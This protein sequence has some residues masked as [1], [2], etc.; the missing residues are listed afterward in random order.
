M[1][2]TTIARRQITRKKIVLFTLLSWLRR[3]SKLALLVI[4][5]L[6]GARKLKQG[7]LY[8][9]V[10]N[11]V[12]AQVKA[13]GSYDLV[14]PNG[15]TKVTFSDDV[16]VVMDN[17]N[18]DGEVGSFKSTSINTENNHGAAGVIGEDCTLANV[19]IPQEEVD[20][21]SARFENSL[22]GY[23]VGR[24][25]AFPVVQNYA[26]N[27]WGKYGFKN[28]MVH[29]GFFM[30]QFSTKESMEN[31]LDQGP[32]RIR[33]VPLILNVWNPISELKREDIKKVPVWVKLFNVPVVAYSKVGLNLIT[34]KLGRLI[35]FDA[36]TSNM[37]LNSW[38]MNSYARV[39]VEISAEK[40]LVQSLVVVVPIDK[41]KGHRLVSI[42][43][44]FEYRP[45]RCSVCKVFDHIDKECHK[46]EKEEIQ[47]TNKE[48]GLGY[49]KRKSKGINQA[50]KANKTSRFRFSN[51]KPKLIYRPVVKPTNTMLS[52]SKLKDSSS[53]YSKED[54][55][56]ACDKP[57]E[58]SN[59]TTNDSSRPTN[60]NAKSK[61]IQDDIDLGQL[62]SYIDKHMKE[63]KT[64]EASK[65]KHHSLSDSEESKV[66]EV[67]MPD[68]ISGG[69]SL[70]RLEDDLDGYDGYEAQFC[71]LNEQGQ[72]FC[73]QYDIRKMTRK[74][75]LHRTERATN[76]LGLIHTN[77]CGP[78]R[79][80][81]RQGAGYF[82][83]FMDDYSLLETF[84]VFNNEVENQL[85]KTIKALRSDREGEYISQEFKDYLKAY[86]IVQQLTPP[87]TP[88]YNRVSKRR[89]HTLLD[90]VRSMMNLI[91]P[92][93]SF[94][95][96]AIESA[97]RILNIVPTKKVD[98]TPY[99]LWYGKVPNVSYLKV[100]GCEALVKRDT[101]DK[102]QQRS[103]KC[104]FIG[105][106]KETMG[107]Y[108][109]FPPENKIV[110]ARYAEFLEKN[111]ISQEVSGR[112]VELE[113]I[114]D[115]DTSPSESTSKIPIEVEGFK[116]PQEEVVPVRRSARIHRAPNR[117]CLNVEVEEH[118]LRDLNEPTNYKAALLDPE[119]DKWLDAM[120][121]KIQS[122]KDNQ[123]W[124][125]VDLSP[126]GKTVGSKWLFKKK[127]DIDGIVHTYKACLVSK[128]FTQTYG[129]DYEETISPIA[130]IR[131]IRILVAIAAFYD[132]EICK[133]DVKTAFLNGY[134]DEDIYMVQPEGFVDP[135]HPRK[136]CKLQ[137]SIYGLKQASRSWNKRFDEEIKRFGFAQNLDEPCVYQKASGSNVTFLILYVD[138]III[139]GNHIPS[140]QSVKS[141]LGKCF[142]M[143]DLGEAAFILGIKIYR[144]R[145]NRLIGLSQS[146]YMDKILKRFKMK[147][148]KHGNIPM[149]ERFDLNKTQGASTP[150]EVKRMKNVPYASTLDLI[151]TKDM[152][153][154]Y[155][156]N[157]EAELRV[158]CYCDA[159]FETDR[160]DIKSQTGYVF[161]LNKGA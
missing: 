133:M 87:Y 121:A 23:F 154:V 65:N 150:G 152:F 83:T 84:K 98:K 156:G 157:H 5:G 28:V 41:N 60:E 94:W 91:T 85:G 8:L 105:Y 128:G 104:I 17:K 53:H 127:A 115:E 40:E 119:S 11:G 4:Q 129:V 52:P 26:R 31:V 118:S 15:L 140:L 117:L 45:P 6:R 134:L 35:K 37:C 107:Y 24:R 161:V 10:G 112:A 50:S 42:E 13:I 124:C 110:V 142:T 2:P 108:F 54:V 106:P 19:I 116:P 7:A 66:E 149:Q 71:D 73:D 90:M 14:L 125:L 72:A 145:S 93:L 114:Q 12:R 130:D 138:D 88:Q 43:I 58:P 103:V 21:L 101:P 141:Y 67:C 95:D 22:Y 18:D 159:G 70:D 51:G 76:L 122:M 79:H 137:R 147:N 44:E 139:M 27:A 47:N 102:L 89:N 46:K 34:A 126:N 131:A 75:F 56:V 82:I 120:N 160:D 109:Y 77:V 25:L 55:N 111:L 20:T 29:Q 80:V 136:V 97:A 33:S 96:Y 144:H 113:E 123:V 1:T 158:D 132:Y 64:R 9:Y 143:K 68:H 148:S 3:G 135:K 30:F 49:D 63:D 69:G 86:G 32:W 61:F 36:H 74:P 57:T 146:D 92:P 153:L 48:D 81:S 78:L 39:L 59:V 151:N 62:R 99:E 100:L 16:A 38:G 155:G